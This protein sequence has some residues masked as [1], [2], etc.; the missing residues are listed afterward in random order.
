M[1]GAVCTLFEKK[2]HF[3]VAALINSLDRYGFQGNI[4]VGYRGSLPNWASE[5]ISDNTI[6]WPNALTLKIKEHV[7]VYFLPVSTEYHL[8]HYKPDFMLTLLSGIANK[9]D[10]LA[11]FDPDIVITCNWSFFEEWISYGV[12]VVHE[13]VSSDMPDNHPVRA[14]WKKVISE[15]NRT[16]THSIY[17]YLNCG[18]CG[19]SIQNIDFLKAWSEA[20]SIAVKSY[21][22]DPSQFAAMDHTKTFWSIDQDAFNIAA[23]SC[24]CSISE[25][26]PEAMNFIGGGFTMSHATGSPKP[27]DKAF[28]SSAFAGKSPS[29]ADKQYWKNANGLISPYSGKEIRSKIKI[30]KIA[31]FIGRF[32]RKH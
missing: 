3:G 2:H 4:Y 5:A 29:L 30:I 26:G 32:Y 27:W 17:S 15:L 23:M 1:A 25:M 11:Y 28:L 7:N 21:N 18:F 19:V 16:Q 14:K 22:M 8:A 31:S 12:A 9:S 13:I 24:E 6:D 10:S 20:C